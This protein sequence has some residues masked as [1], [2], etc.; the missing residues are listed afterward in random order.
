M[1]SQ[2]LGAG[3]GG[4]E[5]GETTNSYK[6]VIRKSIPILDRT[7]LACLVVLC[8]LPQPPAD[9]L[10]LLSQLLHILVQA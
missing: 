6:S 1:E 10:Q 5:C 3:P 8:D 4:G 7:D 2:Y 9:H